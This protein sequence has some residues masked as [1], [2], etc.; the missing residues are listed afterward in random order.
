MQWSNR[1]GFTLTEMAVVVMIMGFLLAITAPGLIRQLNAQ[2]VKDSAN[3]LR[4][5]M[6][7]ARQKAVTNGTRNYVYTQYGTGGDQ[8]W[9]GVRTFNDATKT[10]NGFVWNGP[11]N[12]PSKTKQIGSNFSTYT[13]FYYDPSGKP[14]QPF[15]MSPW[16]LQSPPASGTVK[17]VSTVP[18]ITD[19]VTVNLDLSG[20]VW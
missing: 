13:W 10:W 9:T 6:R 17:F 19:T 14:H 16:P 7:L 18:S 11:I 20:S 3:I 8:Y 2:R 1:R 4:E 15:D 5:E 12:L